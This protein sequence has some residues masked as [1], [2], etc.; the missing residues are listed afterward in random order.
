MNLITICAV[1]LLFIGYHEFVVDGVA[2]E[3]DLRLTDK[4]KKIM[5]KF[6]QIMI[7]KLP[8][9]YMKEEIYLVRWLRATDFDLKKSEE[10]LLQ[11]LKWR[12]QQKMDV[13]HKEDWSDMQHDFPYYI[14][15]VDKKGQPVITAISRDWDIRNAIVTGRIRRVLRYL[16]KAMD[17]ANG[18]VRTFQLEGQNVTQFILI[19]HMGNFNLFQHGCPRC[20]TSILEFVESYENHFPG[21]ADRILLVNTPPAFEP[22]AQL[23]REAMTPST[24]EA[25]K[26]YGNEPK[27]W[28]KLLLDLI[29]ADQLTPEFGGTKSEKPS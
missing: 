1:L 11:N 16:D 10:F 17:E 8:H 28:K 7:P 3:I 24:R 22:I 23:V 25:L 27:V 5:D 6:K 19:L 14:D 4:Q 21:T 26:I 9:N 15:V 18:L 2:V 29:D 13:I 20:I 12:K